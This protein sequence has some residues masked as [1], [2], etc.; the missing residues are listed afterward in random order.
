MTTAKKS[1]KP[2]KAAKK[3]KSVK[4]KKG[5]KKPAGKKHAKKT[6]KADIDT[7]NPDVTNSPDEQGAENPTQ[8]YERLLALLT[9]KAAK[10]VQEYLIDLNKEKAAVRAGYSPKSARQQAF[11]LMKNPAVCAAIDQ[12]KRLISQRIM[13]NQD[14]VI[15]ELALIGF[16]DMADFVRVDAGGTVAV[17]PLDTLGPGK[18][19]IIKSIKEKRVIKSCGGDKNTASSDVVMESTLEFVLHDKVKSLLGILDRVKVGA[20]DP[21]TVEHKHTL[22]CM[23]PDPESMQQ[24]ERDY[25]TMIENAEKTKKA[26]A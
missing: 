5:E 4:A 23:P 19:R 2:V 26:G 9:D 1:A 11:V 20:D 25:K 18:S 22:T 10:F 13:V 21:E 8:K 12:G 7:T 14:E 24:W 17:N 15:K 16:A 6:T 3:K